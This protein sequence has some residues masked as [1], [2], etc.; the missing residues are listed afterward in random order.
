MTKVRAWLADVGGMEDLSLLTS[1]LKASQSTWALPV[2]V[3]VAHY[4]WRG[5]R[6]ERGER[7]GGR[8][9]S[10]IPIIERGGIFLHHMNS[11]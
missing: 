1:S 6:G 10:S 4:R 2:K 7:G 5:G 11:V 8:E 3:A 9:N